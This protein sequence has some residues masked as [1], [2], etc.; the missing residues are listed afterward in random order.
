MTITGVALED[1]PRRVLEEV[2]RTAGLTSVN[3]SSGA[4]NAHQQAQAMFGLIGSNDAAY[5]YDLYGPSGDRV[6]DVYAAEVAKTPRPSDAAII[7]A[8]E[9]KI[10]EVGPGNVSNHCSDVYYTFDVSKWS[11]PADKR[12]AFV[13]ALGA[14]AEVQAFIDENDCYHIQV[15]R[16]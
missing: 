2:A 5:A 13:D 11:V 15:R 6:I 10:N 4:R 16:E 3:V 12:Q 1:T 14:H 9:A 8:M 7:A